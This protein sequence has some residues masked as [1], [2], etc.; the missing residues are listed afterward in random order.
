ML[1]ERVV[2]WKR[3]AFGP[4]WTTLMQWVENESSMAADGDYTVAGCKVMISSMTSE[5][6]G[7]APFEAHKEMVDVQMM[8]AGREYLYTAP[9]QGLSPKAPYDAEK[10]VVFF[11][12]M[13]KVVRVTLEPGI[14][15]LVFP[16]DAHRPSVAYEDG[17]SAV[18]R[19]VAKIPVKALQLV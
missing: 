6:W 5:P 10:D 14:F 2:D 11:T 9:A 13:P 3:Y 18:R 15:A 4:V 17:P 1:V 12:E 7:T 19:L 16:W 8:L